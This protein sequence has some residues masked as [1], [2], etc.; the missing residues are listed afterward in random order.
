MSDLSMASSGDRLR[1]SYGGEGGGLFSLA[2]TT[3]FLTLIT[4]GIYRFWA[5]TRIR[6]YMWSATA[7]GGAPFE[8]TGTGL[9]KFLGF[10]VAVVVLALYL[11]VIQLLLF[12]VGLNAFE[13]GTDPEAIVR[14]TI[15]TNLTLLAVLPLVF[16]AQYRG[17]RYLLSRTRWR[18]IRFGAEAG[19]GGYVLRALGYTILTIIS[20]GLLAPLM[21]YKLEKYMVDRTWYG[22][23]KF[24][25]GGRW[26]MLYG[27]LLHIFISLAIIIAMSM[28]GVAS[29]APGLAV[30]GAVVGGL[31]FYFGIFYYQVD[32]FRRLAQHKK[33]GDYIGFDAEPSVWTVIGHTLL[34][35]LAAGAAFFAITMVGLFIGSAVGF[36]FGGGLDFD[37]LSDLEDFNPAMSPTGGSV[38][39]LVVIFTYLLGLVVAGALVVVLIQQPIIAHYVRTTTILNASQLNNIHQRDGDEMVDAEGFADALD[40]GGGF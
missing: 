22:D 30:L 18:G 36:S 29:D 17:R 26:T 28:V 4:L 27:S 25:Q 13:G 12:F 37:A 20:L 31:W 10:L 21:S 38:L 19:A 40:V 16:F 8:Y 11:G 5:K 39:F 3:G 32:S 6:R 14:Q 1:G 34:G 15:A 33:V 7:P 24:E 35:G 9:E 2:M 23:T